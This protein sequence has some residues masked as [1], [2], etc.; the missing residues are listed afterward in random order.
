MKCLYEGKTGQEYRRRNIEIIPQGNGKPCDIY[1]HN[2][3]QSKQC[4]PQ[5]EECNFINDFEKCDNR[6]Y[7]HCCDESPALY[8]NGY[9]IGYKVP[10][11]L[12]NKDKEEGGCLDET[13]ST[14][15]NKVC[16]QGTPIQ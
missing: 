13:S 14:K 15:N 2:Q 3:F 10:V 16:Y 12:K 1:T 7:N 4:S 6:T 8:I 9:G 5:P 11:C